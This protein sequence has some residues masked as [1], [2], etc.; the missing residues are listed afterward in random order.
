MPG[1]WRDED[2]IA[3]LDRTKLAIN[4]HRSFPFQDKIELLTVLMIMSFG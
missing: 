1:T 4:L 3:R 2:R